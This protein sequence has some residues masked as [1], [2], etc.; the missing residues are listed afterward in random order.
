MELGV[1][2]LGRVGA[3]ADGTVLDQRLG[4]GKAALEGEAVDQRLECRARRADGLRHVD[5]AVARDVK[6]ICGAHICDDLACAVVDD[7]DGRRQLRAECLDVVAGEDLERV[8]EIALER[9]AVD[10]HVGPRL[11]LAL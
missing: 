6:V 9:Q 7:K 1:E 5:G 8:L 11:D 2:V 4:M 3:E 10:A